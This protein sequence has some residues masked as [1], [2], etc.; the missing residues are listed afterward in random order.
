MAPTG[1]VATTPLP[2]SYKE[3]IVTLEKFKHLYEV[4]LRF[5][6]DGK[7][8]GA[9]AQYLEGIKEDGVVLSAQPGGALPLSLVDSADGLTLKGVLGDSL[10]AVI[11]AE[12]D[13]AAARAEMEA[14]DANIQT[15][16]EAAT[17]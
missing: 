1:S 6:A 9:H 17:K 15:M 13:A 7:L 8:Q 5:D 14:K 12:A 16:L 2:P 11:E 3:F 10:S 4:L